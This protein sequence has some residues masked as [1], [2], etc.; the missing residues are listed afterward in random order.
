MCLNDPFKKKLICIRE[1][2]LTEHICL[3]DWQEALAGRLG[4]HIRYDELQDVPKLSEPKKRTNTPRREPVVLLKRETSA[5][6]ILPPEESPSVLNTTQE[7]KTEI[8]RASC[9]N[10]VIESSGSTVELGEMEL[11]CAGLVSDGSRA[12]AKLLVPVDILKVRIINN[13]K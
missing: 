10:G 5:H 12:F 11:D 9:I 6:K 3:K 2:P 7:T 1:S 4:F 8:Q 13:L